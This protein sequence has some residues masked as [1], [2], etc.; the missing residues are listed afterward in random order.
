MARGI[1]VIGCTRKGIVHN[2]SDQPSVDWTRITMTNLL[3]ERIDQHLSMYRT[4]GTEWCVPYSA[5]YIRY[6]QYHRPIDLPEHCGCNRSIAADSVG[7]AT[8]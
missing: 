2:G 4:C 8:L 1:D 5:Q 6:R 7:R 3:D